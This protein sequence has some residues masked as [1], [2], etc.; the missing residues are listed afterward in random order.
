MMR[1]RLPTWLKI[2]YTTWMLIWVPTYW[3]HHG[4]ANFLWLCDMAN[5]FVA[6]AIWLESPLLFSSQAVSVLLI[7]LAWMIDY[8]SRLVLG[9]HLLGGTEYMFD[10]TQPFW[11]RSLSCFHVFV[12][13]LLLWAIWRLGYDRRGWLLQSLIAWLILPLSYVA[14]AP[15]KNLNWLWAP[16]GVPQTLIS[17]P[18]YL[19]L[20]MLAYPLVIFWTTHRLLLWWARSN[21]RPVLPADATR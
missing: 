7:Q 8:C 1:Q 11:L 16:F 4:P 18:R 6:A 20:C 3:I 12:P 10:H 14:A 21:G 13:I 9:F 5:F 2:A 17:P 19:L 15:E